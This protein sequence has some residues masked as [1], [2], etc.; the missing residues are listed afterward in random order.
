[1]DE[2]PVGPDYNISPVESR[3]FALYVQ[4]K[5]MFADH[6]DT[7]GASTVYRR[8]VECNSCWKPLP[9]VHHVLLC[10]R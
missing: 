3:T 9:S 1:M 4:V 8:W 6:D 5:D 7:T 2:R 10:R